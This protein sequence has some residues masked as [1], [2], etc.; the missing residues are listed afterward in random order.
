MV[1]L[2]DFWGDP[3]GM[4]L[5][6]HSLVLCHILPRGCVCPSTLHVSQYLT[7]VSRWVSA[8]WIPMLRALSSV[9]PS[10]T[11]IL[12]TLWSRTCSVQPLPWGPLSPT[13]SALQ[14]VH[15]G[16][17]GCDRLSSLTAAPVIMQCPIAPYV[18]HA[19]PRPVPRTLRGGLLLRHPDVYVK[20][21]FSCRCPLVHGCHQEPGTKCHCPS[22]GQHKKLV[23]GTW[24]T[25]SSL[26]QAWQLYAFRQV[27]SSRQGVDSQHPLLIR[28]CLCFFFSLLGLV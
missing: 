18:T 8:G 5:R 11:P 15:R 24:G 1:R 25:Q 20:G 10:Q 19:Q 22:L 28:K 13:Y 7:Q 4:R 17:C 12:T 21:A 27:V 2:W 3:V 23:R 26:L 9:D 14:K 16:G 6:A